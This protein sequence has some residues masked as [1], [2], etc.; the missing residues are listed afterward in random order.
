M[1]LSLFMRRRGLPVIYL[2]AD[3]SVEAAVALLRSGSSGSSGSIDPDARGQADAGEAA[4][5]GYGATDK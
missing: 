4:E 5:R 1:I 3:V 2:G